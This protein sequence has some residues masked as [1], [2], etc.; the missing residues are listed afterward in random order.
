MKTEEWKPIKG[1]EER[2]FISNHGRVKSINGKYKKSMPDGYIT[3]GTIDI[4]GYYVVTLRNKT[5]NT[6]LKRVHTLVAEYFCEKKESKI[7]LCV[8]H[9]DGNKLNNYF[10]NL[11]WVTK[12]EN[13]AHALATGL[14]DNKGEK[15]MMSKV[16]ETQVLEMRELYKSG[17]VH[18]EIAAKFGICRRQCGDIINGVNW[19]WLK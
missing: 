19:G 1:H 6:Q 7:K 5:E 18:R 16:T 13:C 4:L 11:E 2:F 8:N 9:K 3:F 12:K 15:H 17:M 14:I 10:E